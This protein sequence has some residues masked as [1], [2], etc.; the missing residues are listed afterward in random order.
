[1]ILSQMDLILHPRVDASRKLYIV[2]GGGTATE[3]APVFLSSPP[4]ISIIFNLGFVSLE[5][6]DK[7]NKSH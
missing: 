1:M 6:P 4:S 7:G 3:T 2:T 5:A